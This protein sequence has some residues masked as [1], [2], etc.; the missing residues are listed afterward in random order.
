MKGAP[1][2]LLN[3]RRRFSFIPRLFWDGAPHDAEALFQR[4]HGRMENP[5]GQSK[6]SFEETILHAG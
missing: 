1:A 4:S 3:L 5:L 6:V 2:T